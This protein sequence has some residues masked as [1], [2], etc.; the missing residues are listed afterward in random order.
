VAREILFDFSRLFYMLRVDEWKLDPGSTI[1]TIAH[2]V[3]KEVTPFSSLLRPL[4]DLLERT[5]LT[6]HCLQNVIIQLEAENFT[7]KPDLTYFL[8]LFSYF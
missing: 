2:P 7:P 1:Q 5:H 3:S 8:M 4:F 6:A